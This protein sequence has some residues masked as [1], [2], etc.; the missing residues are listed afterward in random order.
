MIQPSVLNA[1]QH[2]YLPHAIIRYYDMHKATT[3]A[4]IQ[5]PMSDDGQGR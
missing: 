1:L 3:T 4:N 5:Q 2:T